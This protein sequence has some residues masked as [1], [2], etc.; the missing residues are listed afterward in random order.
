MIQYPFVLV[1]VTGL[2]R[3]GKDTLVNF[4]KNH[5][6]GIARVAFADPLKEEVAKALGVTVPFIEA[7]K[8]LF[9][10]I[11]QWWGTEWRRGQ[12]QEYWLKKMGARL[13]ELGRDMFRP[14]IVFITD[15]RFQDEADFVTNRAGIMVKIVN[16]RAPGADGH[17]S[18]RFAQ[19][20]VANVV[21]SNEGS[22]EDLRLE[23]L[24]L[25]SFLDDIWAERHK[26]V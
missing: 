7:N 15:V 19:S 1:G 26:P 3:S 25:L 4:V 2:K 9:R 17:A 8:E 23:A 11:L 22:L 6:Q 10:P 13:V 12:D 14:R 24:R 18:E 20:A 16:S 5:S 21:I